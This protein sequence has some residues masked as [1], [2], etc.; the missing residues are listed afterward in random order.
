MLDHAEHE[1]REEFP[2]LRRE[3]TAAR[4]HTMAEEL[5]AVQTAHN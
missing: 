2:K 4:L 3:L 5:V 1:E